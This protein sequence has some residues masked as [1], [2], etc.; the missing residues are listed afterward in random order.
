MLA[1][2]LSQLS[3]TVGHFFLFHDFPDNVRKLH[4]RPTPSTG[5]IA[6]VGATVAGAALTIPFMFEFISEGMTEFL[7]Y[8][9]A[10]AV[11]IVLTGIID[12]V[13]G[14]SF[15]PKFF[16]QLFAAVLVLWGLE[17]QFIAEHIRYSE[18]PAGWR[19]V[20][21]GIFVLWIVAGC[22]TVNLIDGI[23]GLAGSIGLTS[24]FGI[25]VLS[26]TWGIADVLPVIVP[27]G[28]ALLGFLWLNRPP[29]AI[30]MGDTGSMFTGF[31]IAVSILVLA[32]HATHWM[33]ALALVLLLSIPLM[34]TVFAI[35]R[36]T[37]QGI[38][39]FESDNNHIHHMLQRY[40][41]GPGLAVVTLSAAS[42]VMVTVAILL[43]NIDNP[44]LFFFIYGILFSLFVFIAVIYSVKIKSRT[45][46]I[47]THMIR[48]DSAR[49][50]SELQDKE[51]VNVDIRR[52]TGS[53][54]RDI[55]NSN[56]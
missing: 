13:F 41:E 44:Q 17:T 12:D 40:F 11:V 14:L 29:A 16:M 31:M 4:K 54:G 52:P 48:K 23:D 27:L 39:P 10:G 24:I 51:P 35:I 49:K 50:N 37:K 53:A 20:F 38:N 46:V 19:L 43:S 55:V 22:N 7:L 1:L 9:I 56:K 34:D 2:I 32:V 28:A 8:M 18:T 21:Y 3:R 5:G 15:K 47:Y 36:R 6:V 25:A 26:V 42:M 33:Y 30:F 45:S